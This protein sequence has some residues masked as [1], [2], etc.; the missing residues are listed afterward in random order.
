VASV[1]TVEQT[2]HLVVA[3]LARQT[4][5]TAAAVMDRAAQAVQVDRA[6]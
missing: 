5:A 4:L 3:Q 6:W 2:I 1:V